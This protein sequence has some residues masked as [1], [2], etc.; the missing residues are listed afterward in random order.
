L[1]SVV[2]PGWI[3]QERGS[4]AERRPQF[5]IWWKHLNVVLSVIC[6]IRAPLRMTVAEWQACGWD[7][8]ACRRAIEPGGREFGRVESPGRMILSVMG[9][10]NEL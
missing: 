5:V 4:R 2:Q 9:L 8:W 1:G 3:R 6:G 10:S 7:A